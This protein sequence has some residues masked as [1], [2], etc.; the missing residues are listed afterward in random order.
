M[1]YFILG[2]LDMKKCQDEE[3]SVDKVYICYA[4][5]LHSSLGNII[6]EENKVADTK[7]PIY[8]IV[9]M[10]K[11]SSQWLLDAQLVQSDIGFRRIVGFQEF[12]LEGRDFASRT[13]A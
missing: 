10:S 13:S 2:L 7:T 9:C 1:Y 11:K 12:E 4:A 8:I 3:L 6:H 5:E